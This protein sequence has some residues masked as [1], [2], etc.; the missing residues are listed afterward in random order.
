MRL[1]KLAS[2]TAVIVGMCTA[3]IA[4]SAHADDTPAARN[5]ASAK[6]DAQPSTQDK[7]HQAGAPAG[8]AAVGET[9]ATTI[10]SAYDTPVVMPPRDPGE[11]T[12]I[13]T[14]RTPNTALLVGG[15]SVLVSTYA[16]TAALAA[17]NGPTEDN[18]LYIPIVGP[19]INLA[20]RS[21]NRPDHTRDVIAVTSSGILQ[22][23]GAAL[24]I[25]SFF[26][27]E[28]LAT[29]TITAGGL[30]IQVSPIAEVGQGG[31]R[32]SGRF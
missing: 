30:K 14:K 6:H 17:I 10:T 1:P 20:E 27:P 25:T 28:K 18:R 11:D 13:F 22:G 8:A 23:V 2:T 5:P 32:A 3:S 7:D 4:R 26:V 19:W 9:S 31:L 24:A 29:A 15:G 21:S 12:T 16:V